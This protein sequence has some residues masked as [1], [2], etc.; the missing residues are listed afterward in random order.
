MRIAV[1]FDRHGPYHVARLQGAMRHCEVLAIEGAPHRPI[2]DWERPELP[3]GLDYALLTEKQ[4]E[5]IDPRLIAERLDQRVAPWKPQAVAICGWATVV[6]LVTLK[7]AF[8]RGIPVICMSET[9]SWDFERRWPAEAIKRMIVA[10]FS[11]GLVTNDSQA[12]YLASLGLRADTIFRGYNAIDNAFFREQADRWR[13]DP[14]LPPE[15]AGKLPKEAIG[16]Y[17]LAS[18][19][20]IEKKN[21]LRLLD[22]YAD[23]RQGRAANPADWPLVLLG[24]GELRG[25]I[26]AKIAQLGLD[27]FVHLPGFLQVDALPRYYATAGAF[28]HASTTEQWGLVV[29]EAMASGLPVAASNRCGSTQ[30]L[31]EDGLTGFSFDPYDTRDITR[32]LRSLAELPEDTPLLAAANDRVEE[33]S[34]DRFG[35]GLRQAGDAA[36]RNPAH[37]GLAAKLALRAMIAR[38]A[39]TERL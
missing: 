17:F 20:F 2:Y 34:P 1:L 9:N 33:V 26:E 12:E 19:R 4:G 22:A 27:K 6:D 39:R 23:F 25:R 30:F 3:D 36:Q 28:V 29:N 37:P 15:V 14:E 10:H 35:R 38:L 32:A 8:D 31:I 16:R 5:E 11:A 7:W 18:N 24:D 13:A 21:L